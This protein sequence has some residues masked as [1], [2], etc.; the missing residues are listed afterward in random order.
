MAFDKITYAGADAAAF[1]ELADPN[2]LGL[3]NVVRSLREACGGVPN[4]RMHATAF[5]RYWIGRYGMDATDAEAFVD[6]VWDD[7]LPADDGIR[8]GRARERLDRRD[9]AEIAGGL[10]RHGHDDSGERDECDYS[11]TKMD[12]CCD[13]HGA[14]L[15]NGSYEAQLSELTVS[16]ADSGIQECL[17]NSSAIQLSSL[18]RCR[19]LNDANAARTPAT[20]V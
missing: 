15:A 18:S 9:E 10:R 5:V 16:G 20:S 19:S 11:G 6:E 8:G 2:V 4:G 7:G 1:L 12:S 17:V 3:D 13:S 14:R